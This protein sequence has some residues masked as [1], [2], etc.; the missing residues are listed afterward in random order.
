MP[1]AFHRV[2]FEPD[3]RALVVP[4][5]QTLLEAAR[6][7]GLHL[8]A[9]CGGKGTCGGC[10]VVIPDAPPEPSEVC[11]NVL[12]GEEI[13]RAMRLACQVR[14]THDMRV[15]VPEETRLGDQQILTDGAMFDVPLRPNVSK[16][17]VHL[18]EPS[19][20]DQRSD[21]DRLL[22]ALAEQGLS[23][24][25]IGVNVI[26]DL[27]KR[28][29]TLDFHPAVVVIGNEVVHLDR[30]TAADACYG[31][32][33]DVGTTTLVGYLV[34]LV[35]GDVTAVASRTN[36]QA[37]YGDDVVARIEYA[38]RDR[39]GA[40]TLQTAV[41]DALNEM[42]L[43]VCRRGHIRPSVVYEA[44]MVGNTTMN[45]LLLR[46]PTE[47]IGRAP[48]VAASASAHSVPARAVGLKI[49][50]R[51][52]L[53]TA[54]LVAGFVGAD[55]V[56]VILATGMHEGGVLR[57]AIDV[58]T[59]GEIVLGT[60][61]RILACST[62]AGPAFEG[63]RIRYG[64]RAADGAIDRVDIDGE[65]VVLH[66]I[67]G[68]P[69]VGLCGTGLIDAV[70]ALLAAGVIETTGLMRSAGDLAHAPHLAS[71]MVGAD[72]D[73]G[74]LLAA[75]DRTGVGHPILL[76]QRDVREVQLAKGA[77]AAGIE[78]LLEEFGAGTDDVEEVLLAGAFGNF[79]RP[80]RAQAIGLI[81]PVP[82]EKVRFVGNAAGAGARMLLVNR[83]M[84]HVADDVAR[85]VEHVELSQR[86]DFQ[87][88][89]AEAMYFP[90]ASGQ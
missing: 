76:T 70:A 73:R 22:D 72:G 25:T 86:P 43:E 40:R 27:P 59:N 41:V 56:A 69:P 67:G 3:G 52:R 57:L 68:A 47:A 17:A 83:N 50:E 87:A 11:R 46:L 37:A 19:V 32:A 23:D 71:R 84:R 30:P 58:G 26:R 29:R 16:T 21:A 63:A 48:F 2:V 88:R 60:R 61:E 62:A 82:R 8:E 12:T 39:A 51:G 34:D 20:G 24:L 74:F 31:I 64:M 44:T 49:H 6:A 77:I 79:I 66:T 33:F 53:Y 36:P 75:G 90:Q 15:V 45:H 55:T 5:G 7:A 80:D 1:Q 65:A 42:V 54:P 14:V 10:R 38:G 9:P 85:G 28:L 4:D 18:P 81:P 89:F 78:T 13:D 35:T